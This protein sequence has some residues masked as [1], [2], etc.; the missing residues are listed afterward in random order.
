M[1]NAKYDISENVLTITVDLS[2]DLGKSKSGFSTIVARNDGQLEGVGVIG[3]Q[4]FFCKLLVGKSGST[5]VSA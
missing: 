4:H 5:K 3:D 2:K 1:Q